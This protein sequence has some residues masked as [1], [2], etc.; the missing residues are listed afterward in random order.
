[1]NGQ[2]AKSLLWRFHKYNIVFILKV[3]SKNCIKGI[4][5]AGCDLVE[6]FA[7]VCTTMFM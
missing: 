6:F 2:S 5:L 1:M 4:L 3:E 7:V